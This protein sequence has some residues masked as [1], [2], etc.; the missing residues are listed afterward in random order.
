[1]KIEGFK[2]NDDLKGYLMNF[3]SLK[4]SIKA[5]VCREITSLALDSVSAFPEKD[6]YEKPFSKP[7][8]QYVQFLVSQY[9]SIYEAA[10][11]VT[12]YLREHPSLTPEQLETEQRYYNILF[13]TTENHAFW[14]TERKL[15][16]KKHE[17]TID[18]KVIGRTPVAKRQPVLVEN[19]KKYPS[20]FLEF[21]QLRTNTINLVHDTMPVAPKLI[22]DQ[23]HNFLLTGKT[24]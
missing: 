22:S 6:Y 17:G 5:N 20:E 4:E 18:D 9:N 14:I 10:E 1:V 24:I 8:E 13:R 3:K 23:Y 16:S 12:D 15:W 11:A 7:H 19:L 2:Y 21:S